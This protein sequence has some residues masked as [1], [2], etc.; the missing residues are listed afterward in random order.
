MRTFFNLFPL[1][2]D[3]EVA[4]GFD[5]FMDGV[6]RDTA[7]RMVVGF[8]IFFPRIVVGLNLDTACRLK[9]HIRRKGNILS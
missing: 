2:S 7:M 8:P 5:V 1:I 6:N 9:L 3:C 4:D